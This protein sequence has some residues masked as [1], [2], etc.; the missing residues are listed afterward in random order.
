MNK[1]TLGICLVMISL[2]LASF[3]GKAKTEKEEEQKKPEVGKSLPAF[4]LKTLDGKEF[5]IEKILGKKPIIL[6]FWAT[7]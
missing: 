5:E 4:Q 7:W 3:P 6:N 1:L 2:L